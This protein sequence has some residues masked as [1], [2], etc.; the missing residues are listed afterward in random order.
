M[1]CCVYIN[2][3]VFKS[4]FQSVR[5]SVYISVFYVHLS[6]F[7]SVCLSVS[8]CVCQ[9]FCLSSCILIYLY[10]C[11]CLRSVRM[12]LYLLSVCVSIS[13]SVHLSVCLSY[14][15]LT[16]FLDHSIT[17]KDSHSKR[18][19]SRQKIINHLPIDII[20]QVRPRR[21]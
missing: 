2:L 6:V 20:Q 18:T 5:F 13:G 3:S 8:V 17:T 10:T 15:L 21:Y 12:C 4:I 14:Q 7:M 1:S 16:F 19:Q 11:V 9:C